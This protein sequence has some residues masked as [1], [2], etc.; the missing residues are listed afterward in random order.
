MYPELIFSGQAYSADQIELD[1]RRLATAL[2]QHGVDEGGVVAIMLRN[3][4]PFV[5]TALASRDLGA[6][7]CPINWHFKR[8]EAAHILGDC[9]ARVLII[10]SDLFELIGAGIPADIKVLIADDHW[11]EWLA[12]HAPWPGDA[13]PRQPRGFIP[14][15]S[16]TTGKP[17][18][19]KRVPPAP[20]AAAELAARAK[21]VYAAVINLGEG[22]RTLVSA[23]LYHSAPATYM[24]QA[25]IARATLYLEPRF[26]AARTVKLIATEKISHAYMVPTMFHRILDLPADQRDP[27]SLASLSFVTCTGSPCPPPLKARFHK[28]IGPVIYE[29]YASS[30]TGYITRISPEES[31]RKPGSVG[32]AVGTASIMILGPDNQPLKANEPGRI[33]ARQP[34]TPDFDYIN[35]HEDRANIESHG[36]V[37]VG[38]I[39]YLDEDGYLYLSDRQ[40]DMVISG[41]VNIYPAEIEAT[42]A[43]MPQVHDCAVFGI[44]DPEFGES[45]ACAVQIQP[46]ETL[47]IEEVQNWIRERMAA[48][49]VPREVV[50][51]TELPREE[52]GKIFKRRL[53]A[54]Y[55]EAAGR[56]I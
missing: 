31:A 34:G 11:P 26:D 18:G 44:P 1:C 46:G 55:W 41:G 51:H 9:G 3:G 13:S 36:L 35:R 43:M 48:Y 53:R 21:D 39:G 54:P 42:L 28:E 7:F 33:F 20:E 15:T 29:C 38:D 52:T 22:V 49:K 8:D 10:E 2:I 45:L 5:Q 40:S 16:G 37:S 23:P 24:L 17:K 30:E 25:A 14:Y 50:F 47:T 56:S 19:V 27:A 12:T 4:L 32:K 6:H